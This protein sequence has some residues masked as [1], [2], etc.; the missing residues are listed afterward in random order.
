TYNVIS[1]TYENTINVSGYIQAAKSQSLTVSSAGTVEAV[2]VTEGDFVKAGN[3]LVQLNNSEEEY[4]LE[5]QDYDI[6]QKRMAGAAREVSLMMKQREMKLDRLKDKQVIAMFDGV[7]ASLDVS[8]GD[9]LNTKDTVGTLVNRDYLK[10]DVQIVET[11]VAKLKIGQSVTCNFPAYPEAII[12]GKLVS[13]PSVAEISS[14]GATFVNAEVRIYD[15]P[16]EILPNYSFTGEIEISPPQTVLLV[17]KHA[18]GYDEEIGSYAEIIEKNGSIKKV[19]VMAQRYDNTYVR[20]N[21]GLNAGDVLIA[22]ID[23]SSGAKSE[24]T[25][26]GVQGGLVIPGI[27][28][29]A[30][31]G[32]GFTRPR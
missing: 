29:G 12:K 31:R 1:E 26:T 5:K 22:Q 25:N 13:W 11:D 7:V 10:A 32:T 18:I 21:A 16:E 23:N 20:I 9:Y 24:K 2:Y 28:G 15:A 30:T 19:F 14:S 6:E 4:N 3:V 17:Q 27:H 8:K